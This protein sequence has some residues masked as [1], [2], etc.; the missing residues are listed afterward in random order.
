MGAASSR[1]LAEEVLAVVPPLEERSWPRELEELVLDLALCTVEEVSSVGVIAF[2]AK[3][4]AATVTPQ[5]GKKRIG[6]SFMIFVNTSN[7][8]CLSSFFMGKMRK[9]VIEFSENRELPDAGF[10]ASV[11]P[12]E[13][14][15]R[16]LSS[17]GEDT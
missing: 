10:V 14:L 2:P 8:N 6:F 13:Y 3:K 12:D 16:Q 15:G 9:E 1:A 17:D 7:Y 5:T 11:R 4:A